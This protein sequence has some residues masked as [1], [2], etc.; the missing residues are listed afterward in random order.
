MKITAIVPARYASSRFPG[1]PLALLG[2]KPVIEHVYEQVSQVVPETWVATDDERI[3]DAVET[4]GGKVVMTRRD[5]QSGTDRIEE[6]VEKIGS[7]ADIIINIQGDEPFV[8]ASQIRT[9]CQLFEDAETQIATL[10]KPFDTMEAVDNPNSPKI[11]T[12]VRG[13][14]LYFS[15][16]VIPFVRGKVHDE[17]LEH[18]PYLKHLGI[19]AYRREVLREITRLPQS[20]LELAESLEQLRWLQQGYRIKVGLTHVETIGIDTPA[21]LERA[22]AFWRKQKKA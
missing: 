3:K 1:K 14:A 20:P 6:A 15:R 10:G 12:D 7:D 16:S 2:G 5:H 4:F 21:D 18:F 13:F 8:Q 19:Y 9:V 11:V 17:W 22:E